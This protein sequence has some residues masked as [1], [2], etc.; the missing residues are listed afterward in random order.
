MH[1]FIEAISDNPVIA[2]AQSKD[3]LECAVKLGVPTVFLINTD[4]FSAKEYV[5]IAKNAGCNV[6]LHMDLIEG[7]AGNTKAVDYVKNRINPSGIISTKS[8]L[9]K[10]AREQG[11][12][13][14]QRF[15]MVDN[16]SYENAV[17]TIKNT[18]PSMVELMPGIIPDV[19]RRFTHDVDT[20]VIAGGLITHKQQI[21]DALSCG[22]LGVS[23]G[24]TE[25]WNED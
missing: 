13:C 5:S 18:K 20:P 6:F 23:T 25:L 22:A 16:A 1:A 24:C 14:I 12:F 10:Y 9:I 8:A 3:K 7:L 11:I 19:I 21:I 17:S 2:A 4:I 15:F